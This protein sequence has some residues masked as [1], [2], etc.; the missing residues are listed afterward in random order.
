MNLL[1]LYQNHS[2]NAKSQRNA[3][4]NDLKLLQPQEALIIL[5][6][7]QNIK[8]G[9]SP[10][11]VNQDFYHTTSINYLSIFVKTKETGIFFDFS[12]KELAKD[13]YF[14][15]ECFELLFIH[16]QFKHLKIDK[17]IVWSDVGKHFRNGMLAYF[18]A[19]LPKSHEIFVEHNFFV[20]SHGKNICDVHFSQVEF[21]FK[22]NVIN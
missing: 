16:P 18:F 19:N 3:M 7:K 5:D 9:G 8:L 6:F 15:I 13:A 10:E 21:Y 22:S 17:I 4:K 11:E 12:S 1:L 2:E 20:E 14:V